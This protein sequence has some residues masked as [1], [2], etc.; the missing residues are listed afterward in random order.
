MTDI[1]L[2]QAI[3]LVA[4]VTPGPDFVVVSST[5]LHSGRWP[6]LATALFTTLGMSV[7]VLAAMTGI[8]FVFEHLFVLAAAL[9]I[10]GGLYLIFLAAQLIHRSFRRAGPPAAGGAANVSPWRAFRRGLLVNL[11]NPKALV[12]FT[13]LAALLVEPGTPSWSLAVSGASIIAITLAWYVVVVLGLTHSGVHARYQA[14]RHWLDR[15]AGA[16]LAFFGV[17][18]ITAG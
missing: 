7:W 2:V 1:L 13:S 4:V 6:G 18:L 15:L 17:R 5:A 14:F 3:F 10:A 12:L 11:G 8:T 9:R 16:V